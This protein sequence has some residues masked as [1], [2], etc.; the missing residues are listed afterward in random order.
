MLLELAK[1]K[2]LGPQ[3]EVAKE[4]MKRK[5]AEKKAKGNSESEAMEDIVDG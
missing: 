4:E 3:I 5:L 1:Q 2:K